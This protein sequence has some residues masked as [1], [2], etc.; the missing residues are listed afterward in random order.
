MLTLKNYQ[1]DA[2]ARLER[3]FTLTRAIPISEAFAAV[4]IEAGLVNSTYRPCAV[5]P[6]VPYVCVRIPTGGGKTALA[7]HAVGRVATSLLLGNAVTV[8]WLV[9][10]RAILAQTADALKDATH[11]YRQALEQAFGQV[12][13]VAGDELFDLK[14]QDLR[15]G[16]TVV[17]T[18]IASAR[19]EE[20][21]QRA[22][23][24]P[25]EDFQGFFQHVDPAQF[26]L[27]IDQNGRPVYSFANVMRLIRPL[28]LVDEAHN[29]RTPLTFTTLARLAPR[30]IVE[31]T[32]TPDRSVATGSNIISSVTAL[33]LR[34]AEM[35]KLPIVLTEHGSWQGAVH[36]ALQDRERLA[37]IARSSGDAVRPVVLFQAQTKGHDADWQ[38]LLK[39][40][41]ESEGIAGGR[42][43]VAT[44]GRNDLQGV[45]LLD[46]DSPIDFVITVAALREGWD[47][48]YA[49]VLCALGELRS[50]TAVEQ[51]LGRVLRMPYAARRT[52]EALNRAYAHV[53][54]NSFA[55]AASALHE[56]LVARL[57][58]DDA[59]AFDAVTHGQQPFSFAASGPA[60]MP[61]APAE[62][63]IITDRTP[64][65]SS[66]AL[67]AGAVRIETSHV[68]GVQV[69]VTGL[70][71]EHDRAAIVASVSAEQR[72]VV[73]W[74]LTYHAATLK[75]NSS[76]SVL[77]K[78]FGVPLLS[79]TINDEVFPATPSV[80][81]T[82]ANWDLRNYPAQLDGFHFDDHAKSYEYDMECGASGK[83]T[84][85]YHLL[86][87]PALPLT[88]PGI[89]AKWTQGDLVRWLDHATR[90]DWT[91]QVHRI[92][93]LSRLVH[94]LVYERGFTIETMAMAKPFLAEAIKERIAVYRQGAAYASF[95]QLLFTEQ[96]SRFDEDLSFE[97]K[98]SSYHPHSTYVGAFEFGKHYYPRIGE[99]D[100]KGEEFDCARA[101]DSLDEIEYWVRNLPRQ[102]IASFWLPTSSDRFYPDFIARL[103]DGRI[104]AI[105]YKGKMLDESSDTLE[106]RAI[107]ELWE[108]RSGGR[109]L[110]LMAVKTD[111]AGRSTLEQLKHKISSSS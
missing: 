18:T 95:Q 90:D 105:E 47:C 55:D 4:S 75:H 30:C 3:F 40:L 9:P 98:P 25:Y 72:E 1:V 81:L 61:I 101:L 63:R 103:R 99:L 52:E 85:R 93:W 68:A 79:F 39:H 24:K 8:L 13:V 87:Q 12:T 49:Y 107:G 7:A 19:I 46:P 56:T 32:A 6:A 59:D 14:P 67:R 50:S 91:P 78:Q 10:S 84:L 23:Y 89:V 64:N 65:V 74:E 33:E 20:T 77:G 111:E 15:N 11:W 106:K 70:I 76:P 37:A 97:F 66:A 53:I 43:A 92:G 2:L 83:A 48:S 60:P 31:F 104:F 45:D 16:A 22:F 108:T 62:L 34:D 86:Q 51:I 54:S 38:H 26:D 29:A 36:A 100:V 41:T 21:E 80:F 57:G 94:H 102:P 17:V 35:I 42:V 73:R 5:L 82:A 44:G 28:V 27:E 110:F 96:G 69:V 88:L 71:N 58:F 109:C